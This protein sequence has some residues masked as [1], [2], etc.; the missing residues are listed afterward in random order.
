[1]VSYRIRE[2]TEG[3]L[4]GILEI[5]RQSFPTPW[6]E[7]MFRAQMRFGDISIHLVL[8]LEGSVS[9]YATA[10]AVSDEMHLLSIAVLPE[11]RRLGYGGAIL[12]AVIERGLAKGA[13]R[14]YLE[15]REGNE[16]AKRFY[17]GRGFRVIGKRKRYYVDTGEDAIVM[18]LDL[19]RGA[20]G[21][22]EE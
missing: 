21:A 4:E 7:W 5:E 1:M 17:S 18:E 19:E 15:V 14:I 3:D 8:V 13:Q 2:M 12:G 11:K 20:D 10:L 16:A 6:T 22:T 9:A